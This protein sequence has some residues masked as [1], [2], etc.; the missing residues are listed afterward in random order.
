MCPIGDQFGAQFLS[1]EGAKGVNHS[2]IHL[3]TLSKVIEQDGVKDSLPYLCLIQPKVTQIKLLLLMA[4]S[5]RVLFMYRIFSLLYI[6]LNF[7]G[8]GVGKGAKVRL[9]PLYLKA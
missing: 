6:N 9:Y 7:R 2:G 5:T 1:N 4:L 3:Q 8:L